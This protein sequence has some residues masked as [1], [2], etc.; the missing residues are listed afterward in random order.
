VLCEDFENT[1]NHTGI[2]VRLRWL[3]KVELRFANLLSER[4]NASLWRQM[5]EVTKFANLVRF[6]LVAVHRLEIT[7]M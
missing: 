2:V 6:V 1:G 7:W 3:L 4:E 5:I